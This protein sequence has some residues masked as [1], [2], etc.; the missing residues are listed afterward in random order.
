MDGSLEVFKLFTLAVL[1]PLAVFTANW[2]WRFDK[3]YSQTSAA[4]FILC[5]LI[6][7]ITAV[8]ASKDFEPFVRS[9]ELVPLITYWH[10]AAGF[11][12]GL[13]W[14]GITKWGEPQ[15]ERH[16]FEN[17]QFPIVSFSTCWIS[18]LILIACHIGFFTVAHVGGNNV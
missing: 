17:A 14:W 3:G 10:F 2:I 13:V 6:F 5:I 18:V 4:D 16:Y 7:D 12:S 15:L 8:V 11:V 1:I 9:T